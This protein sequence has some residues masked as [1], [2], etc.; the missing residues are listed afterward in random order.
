M[1]NKSSTKNMYS[2][3]QLDEIPKLV[4]FGVMPHILALGNYNFDFS[5][6]SNSLLSN[7]LYS[8]KLI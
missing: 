1:N 5:H 6:Y 7:Y 2:Q 4:A 3:L 8:M